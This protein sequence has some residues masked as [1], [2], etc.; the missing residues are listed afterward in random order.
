MSKNIES[1][2]TAERCTLSMYTLKLNGS[3]VPS[4]ID[5]MDEEERVLLLNH[6][7]L[8]EWKNMG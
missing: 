4:I 6:C 1:E 2:F 7:P 8:S 3:S 5:D